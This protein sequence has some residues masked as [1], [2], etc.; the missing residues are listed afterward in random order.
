[1][2]DDRLGPE[3]TTSLDNR[4]DTERESNVALV[5]PRVPE[6][7]RGEQPDRHVPGR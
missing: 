5:D 2:L 6:R 3:F 7:V 4:L 1:M